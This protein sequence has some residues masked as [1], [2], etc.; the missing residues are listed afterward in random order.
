MTAS[1]WQVDARLASFGDDIFQD[2]SGRAAVY[3]T[4]WSLKEIAIPHDLY[5]RIMAIM[6]DNT[7]RVSCS[8]RERL[9]DF[10]IKLGTDDRVFD[11]AL[12][13]WEYILDDRDASGNCS[14]LLLDAEDFGNDAGPNNV[15]L[16]GTTFLGWFY[17]IFDA[18]S[19]TITGEAH[20]GLFPKVS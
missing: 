19:K 3:T 4:M 16:L 2:L 10:V 6:G 5:Q 14:H 11:F 20:R 13:P 9:P 1:G 17:H 7:G 8:I 12:D 15:V 18:D